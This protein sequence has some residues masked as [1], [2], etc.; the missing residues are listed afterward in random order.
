MANK[1]SNKQT[2]NNW[3]LSV[4]NA[5]QSALKPVVGAKFSDPIRARV[6]SFVIVI[7]TCPILTAVNWPWFGLHKLNYWQSTDSPGRW[8]HSFI[9][10]LVS[11]TYYFSL[12]V[13]TKQLIFHLSPR[14]DH[15][16]IVSGCL[17]LTA[18]NSSSSF[19]KAAKWKW[20][21]G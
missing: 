19:A 21:S 3:Q 10:M 17:I 7:C 4:S 2:A 12:H 6:I 13:G 9:F 15:V 1:Y 14:D 16:I 11:V 18:V 5:F 8:K 20:L